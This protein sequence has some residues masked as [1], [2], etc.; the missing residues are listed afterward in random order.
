MNQQKHTGAALAAEP[1][2]EP[3]VRRWTEQGWL[4]DN[5]IRA[6]GIDWDQPR[7][8]YMNAAC[9]F[10]A[11]A[12]FAA[13]RQRVQKYADVVPA[14]VATAKRREDKARAAEAEGLTVTARD[15]YFMAAVHWGAAQ[16]P[17]HAN[18][19]ENLASNPNK[20]AAYGD[21]ARL[22]DHPI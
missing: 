4:V 22:A 17:L 11:S 15:N 18:D 6:N 5:S 10:E 21:Y 3:N 16:W 9:G 19:A 7:S 20:R 14:F 12:D 2:A 8:I 13:I 1:D